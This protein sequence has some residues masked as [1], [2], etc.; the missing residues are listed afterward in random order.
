MKPEPPALIPD[1]PEAVIQ[2]GAPGEGQAAPELIAARAQLTGGELTQ[3]MDQYSAMIRS[4][5]HLDQVIQDLQVAA[6]R[7]PTEINIWQQLGDACLRADR[8]QDALE[9]FIKAEQLLN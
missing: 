5:A 6:D 8:V 9:A 4:G 2:L 7:F 3:A 1:E